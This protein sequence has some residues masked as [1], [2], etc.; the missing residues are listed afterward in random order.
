MSRQAAA[1]PS[2][3]VTAPKPASCYNLTMPDAGD[4]IITRTPCRIDLAGSTVDLW[5]LYLFHPGALTLNFAISVLTTCRLT[6]LRGREIRLKSLDTDCK[7]RFPSL[8]ALGRARRF[9]HPLA[10]R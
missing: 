7:E 10:A 2:M 6:P 8:D 5:P 9:R 1:M 3:P 4:A